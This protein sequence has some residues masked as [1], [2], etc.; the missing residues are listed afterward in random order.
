MPSDV[1]TLSTDQSVEH[2]RCELT[3]AREQQAATT[4]I[5]RVI[6]GSPMD[7]Q[8]VFAA[9]AASA[10]RLCEAN[11]AAI[12]RMDEEKARGRMLLSVH[13]DKV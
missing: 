12:H 13:Q 5:L 2:L 9:I 1:P 6:S 3:E 10:V 4:E 7:L 8:G 11:D